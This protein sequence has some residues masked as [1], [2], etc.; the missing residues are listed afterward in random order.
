[1]Q[2]RV[3]RR[4]QASAVFK[5]QAVCANTLIAVNCHMFFSIVIALYNK[6][7]YIRETLEAAVSQSFSD[8]EII[9]VDDGSTD[10]G[11]DVV[12]AVV[13]TRIRLVQQA[14]GGVAAA[15][16]SGIAS[17]RGD[18]IAFLDAD[19]IWRD[20]YLETQAKIILAHS[21]VNV[22]GTGYHSARDIEAWAKTPS[23][24]VAGAAP[25]ELITDLPRRWLKGAL[26]FTS[27]V[28]VKASTLKSMQPCFAVGESV[29]ED[30]DLWFRL[31]EMG[32]IAFVPRQLVGYRIAVSGNLTGGRALGVLPPY[33]TRMRQRAKSGQMAGTQAQSALFYIFN[34]QINVARYCI[35]IGEWRQAVVWVAKTA[36]VGVMR[37]R[38]WITLLM[39]AVP[40]AWVLRWTRWRTRRNNQTGNAS[41]A[42]LG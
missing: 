21:S 40:G 34:D 26:F 15:R 14:N 38:W 1:M 37:L 20:S 32:P 33:L 27:S 17:A 10:D 8:F 4:P 22:V 2:G 16:N 35:E 24:P 5:Q 31:G 19:D 25:V 18:W 42:N 23:A 9:V 41:H 6:S 29:G 30:L 3:T 28:C 12:K 36:F 13:D 11:V 39:L 7:A